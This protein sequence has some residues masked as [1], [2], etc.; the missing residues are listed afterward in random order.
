[1]NKNNEKYRIYTEIIRK[2]LV[3]ATGCT[4]PIALAYAAAR[5]KEILGSTP[6]RV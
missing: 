5:C 2:E 3:L 6:K 4:E 1:M